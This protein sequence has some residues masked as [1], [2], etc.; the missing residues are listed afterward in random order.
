MARQLRLVAPFCMDYNEFATT[1]KGELLWQ[2]FLMSLNTRAKCKMKSSIDFR[3]P[4]SV[5]IASV[6]R[7][8]YARRRPRY[9]FGMGMH[10]M[11]SGRDVIR[12]R[13]PTFR[14]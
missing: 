8:L 11:Y 4:A 5:I 1:F 12:L 7:S 3:K 10:W 9:S 6:H 2:E 14:C 13:P